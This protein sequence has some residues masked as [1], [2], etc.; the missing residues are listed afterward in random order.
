MVD[1]NKAVNEHA[2]KIIV[3]WSVCSVGKSTLA[4]NL[5]RKLAKETNLKIGLLDFSLITPCLHLF[6]DLEGKESSIEYILKSWQDNY[7]YRDL[8]KENAHITKNLPNLLCWTGLTKEPELI[9]K[10]GDIQARTIISELSDLVDIL[11]IDVQSDTLIIPTDVALRTATDVLV[12]VDQ[13]RSTIENT[14]KW[15]NNLHARNMDISKFKL[16]INQ[17]SSKALYTKNKIESNLALPLL[18]TIPCVSKVNYDNSTVSLI[19]LLKYGK[20]DK[21]IENILLQLHLYKAVKKRRR[22]F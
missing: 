12:I 13:N 4:Y 9:D 15:L 2:K 7:S 22:L 6:L 14:A 1:E 11:I 17:Y 10:L 21:S 8:L 3:L 18:G 20:F 16:I 5:A 19:P